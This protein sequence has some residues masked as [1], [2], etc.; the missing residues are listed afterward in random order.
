MEA[1]AQ[2]ISLALLG[3]SK[4]PAKPVALTLSAVIPIELADNP[5]VL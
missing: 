3:L 2:G 5:I 1:C 4:P